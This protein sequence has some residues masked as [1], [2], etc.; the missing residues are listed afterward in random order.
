MSAVVQAQVEIGDQEIGR[1]DS[2]KIVQC[3]GWHHT[4]HLTYSPP[5][6]PGL[7]M[8]HAEPAIGERVRISLSFATDVF[9]GNLLGEAN[10]FSGIVR[11]IKQAQNKGHIS[12]EI[13]AES[14]TSFLDGPEF[15]RS[16]T[17]KTLQEIVE[18]VTQ[19]YEDEL[20]D[21]EIG[22]II[23]Q[24]LHT[25]SIPYLVQYRESNMQFLARIAAEY[26]E[27]FYHDGVN[28]YFAKPEEDSI[29]EL[30]FSE[31]NLLSFETELLT[32]VAN[33]SYKSYDP[34]EHKFPE[35][36][37]N[38][39]EPLHPYTE[40]IYNKSKN[41]IFGTKSL[42]LMP[43]GRNLDEEE[44]RRTA[45][46]RQQESISKMLK[47]RGRSTELELKVGNFIE[48][49]PDAGA[50]GGFIITKVEHDLKGDGSY[51]NQFEAIPQEVM[52]PVQEREVRPPFCEA[53]QAEVVDTDDPKK[54]GRIKVAFKW[55][56]GTEETSPWIRLLT[57][58]AGGD[59]G[60]FYVPEK[61]DAVWVDFE[62]H[63]PNHPFAVSSIYH[64]K[65]KPSGQ[66]SENNVKS[67]VTRSGNTISL[68]DKDGE[69]TII[70]SS[71][72]G[73]N[74]MTFVASSE[75]EISIQSSGNIVISAKKNLTLTG[76][77]VKI[78]AQD[79]LGLAGKF[80]VM[81]G[82]G[83]NEEGNSVVLSGTKVV[84]SGTEEA[85]LTGK[86]AAVAG[87]MEVAVTAAAIKLN[88]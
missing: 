21:T 7:V 38:P 51:F 46:L 9:E 14:L 70:V 53:Q 60:F 22:A 71:P 15:T 8:D 58:Y 87:E 56:Q 3:I 47:L 2:L 54:M 52:V 31:G 18:S 45:T 83:V 82:R 24:P 26:G 75:P 17:K 77:N 20:I 69:E 28:L 59:K 37:P 32:Q 5:D 25:Q 19:E 1:L 35:H 73:K 40:L 30:S 79:M 66:D 34:L 65:A 41:Q 27:W 16:F 64:G 23:N 63:H 42:G 11:G 85:I 67:W 88:S 81:Q 10:V 33:F 74:V 80:A 4:M 62:H 68:S 57:P 48:V 44:L 36:E 84:V 55:Q 61:K 29:Y 49:Q 76:E 43:L 13:R 50:P 39:P 72:G 78:L 12:Y 86:K 6:D